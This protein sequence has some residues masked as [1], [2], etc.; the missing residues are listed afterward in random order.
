MGLEANVSL[1]VTTLDLQLV[2]L[3]RDA[4][5]TTPTAATLSGAALQPADRFEPRPHLHPQPAI[6]SRP[7]IRP[8][9][10]FEPRPVV[11]PIRRAVPLPQ[12]AGAPPAGVA[13][14]AKPTLPN[15]IQPP[16]KLLAW[17]TPI[18]PKP[19]IKVTIYR[20]DIVSK[21]SLLDFFI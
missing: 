17:R 18:P 9:P 1:I 20:P 14:P 15:P 2:R 11:H 13:A 12:C 7:H 10:R 3:L 6:E 5:K 16:W 8:A 19:Q 21:G 4:M